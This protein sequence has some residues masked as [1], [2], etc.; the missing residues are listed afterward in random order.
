MRYCQTDNMVGLV[1]KEH[2]LEAR[3]K[4]LLKIQ[5]WMNRYLGNSLSDWMC[6][7]RLVQFHFQEGDILHKDYQ[8][9]GRSETLQ[10]VWNYPSRNKCTYKK[11]E[12]NAHLYN[13]EAFDDSAKIKLCNILT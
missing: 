4:I 9:C 3:H 5:I 13:Q 2:I 11:N 1:A 7:N 12:V 8:G 10:K 6:H